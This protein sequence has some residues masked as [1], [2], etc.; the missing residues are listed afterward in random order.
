VTR[1]EAEASDWTFK[2]YDRYIT[3]RFSDNEK[4]LHLALTAAEKA[5]DKAEDAQ[6]LRN[7]QQNEIRA[8][9]SDLSKLMWTRQEGSEAV[10]AMR[11]EIGIT[12]EALDK[13]S[14]ILE[15]GYANIQ[16]RMWAI[17][18]IWGV[19]VLAVSVGVRFLH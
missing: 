14:G 6:R 11:R 2:T 5:V 3:Q 4:A 17:S 8:A 10:L 15:T 19:L 1:D 13:R 12:L 7:E 18:A 16:G 9:L